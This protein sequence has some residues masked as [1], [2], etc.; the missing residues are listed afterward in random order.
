LTRMFA[1]ELA[2]P[3]IQCNSLH[4][5][6]V[7]T[8]VIHNPACYGLAGVPGATRAEAELAFKAGNLLPISQLEPIDISNTVLWLAANTRE[9]A[10][11]AAHR[12]RRGPG[13]GRS[14]TATDAT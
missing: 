2:P 10:G 3:S 1:V 13:A 9:Q 11:L 4:P 12:H 7:N 5:G 8:D 14:A 6:W